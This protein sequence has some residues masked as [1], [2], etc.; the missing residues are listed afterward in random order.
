VGRPP[1]P[2]GG[3]ITYHAMARGNDRRGIFA[4]DDDRHDFLRRLGR[5]SAR[6]GWRCL[7]YCLMGNHF[8]LVVTTPT[9]SLPDGMRDLLGG[10]ARSANRR[11]EHTGHLFGDRYREVVVDSDRQLVAALAYVLN[12]PV[13]A[14]L[15]TSSDRWPWSSCAAL[16]GLE[17]APS[18]L[19]VPDALSVLSGDMSAA[20]EALRSLLAVGSEDLDVSI[21]RLPRIGFIVP[22]A[23]EPPNRRNRELRRSRLYADRNRAIPRRDSS[24]SHRRPSASVWGAGKGKRKQ[25]N[26]EPVN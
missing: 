12:N 6:H 15:V 16:L 7:A 8:H 21:A 2:I 3:G 13:R 23:D 26:G 24:A 10:F 9:G 5:V 20:R 19:S 4:S 25:R 1:R 11:N 14:D 22:K 18:F 17:P